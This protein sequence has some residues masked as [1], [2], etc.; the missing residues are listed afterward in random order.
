MICSPETGPADVPMPS[1][2]PF[3][4]Q[5][6]NAPIEEISLNFE[7]IKV[8]HTECD[9][10]GLSKGNVEYSWKVEGAES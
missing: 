4:V 5:A 8:T 6:V 1:A 9:S 2:G 10:A 7:E 3:I